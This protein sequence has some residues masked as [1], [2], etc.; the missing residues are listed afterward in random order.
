MRIIDSNNLDNVTSAQTGRS[1]ETSQIASS[2]K[3]GASAAGKNG[4]GDRVELSGFA[5]RV[6]QVMAQ[7]ASNRA[8]R[9]AQLTAAVRS[10]SFQVD[11]AAVGRAMVKHAIASWGGE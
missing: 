3:S 11:S 8:E 2:G 7:D 9:V 5:G 10:G 1:G 6:S 4:A